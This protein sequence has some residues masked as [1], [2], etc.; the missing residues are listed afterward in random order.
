[1]AGLA[2]KYRTIIVILVLIMSASPA[3]NLSASAVPTTRDGIPPI[4]I[5][6]VFDSQRRL[7]VVYEA[8]D[9][10]TY[11]G[12]VYLDSDPLNAPTPIKDTERGDPMHCRTTET[13][14]TRNIPATSGAGHFTF[15]SK[16]LNP[17]QF[18]DG[19]YYVQVATYDKDPDPSFRGTLSSNVV[20]VLLT[21]TSVAPI[22]SSVSLNVENLAVFKLPIDN[23]SQSCFLLRQRLSL[24]NR[25][26]TGIN[27]NVEKLNTALKKV[28]NPST[29]LK[30][31]LA[32]ISS[33]IGEVSAMREKGRTD[34]NSAC[35]ATPSLA[36]WDGTFIP[37]PIPPS[38]GKSACT[39]VR[40]QLNDLNQ[41]LTKVVGNIT[42]TKKSQVDRIKQLK[43]EFDQLTDKFG[44]AWPTALR[45][46]IY[47]TFKTPQN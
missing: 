44:K 22:A 3:M 15:L 27:N 47:L 39:E 26:V 23:G 20:V 36:G 38:N 34:A 11:G 17:M 25:Y 21:P 13:C 19:T 35:G 9:G 29:K 33:W 24:G 10:L 16:P 12:T 14:M 6:A 37:I 8:D 42:K 30:D 45:E 46:C 1:M 31:D 7:E 4:I 43:N 28:K 40:G 41:K 32:S 2:R 18:P 5:S